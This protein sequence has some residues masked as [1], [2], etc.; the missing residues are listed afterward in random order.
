[1]QDRKI[2][3]LMCF[4]I[5]I[6]IVVSVGCD[7]CD[8]KKIE[9]TGPPE[10]HLTYIPPIGSFERLKGEVRNVDPNSVAVAVYIFVEGNWWTKPYWNAP[11]TPVKRDGTW[12]CNIT[13]GGNDPMATKIRAY[14]IRKDYNPPLAPQEGL[15]PDPPT[16][17]VL[18]MVEVTR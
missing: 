1:M 17:D 13:T 3:L 11:K 5:A 12:L 9:V 10:I 2:V 18:A 6:L 16:S 4:V 8:R 15:P 14:L 7:G